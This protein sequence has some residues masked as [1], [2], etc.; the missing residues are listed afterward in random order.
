MWKNGRKIFSLH[1]LFAAFSSAKESW[2]QKQW[3]LSLMM[4]GNK[5][6]LFAVWSSPE[7]ETKKNTL[8]S[9]TDRHWWQKVSPGESD[10]MDGST[11]SNLLLLVHFFT[12][13]E[14][15]C[16]ADKIWVMYK[17]YEIL[18]KIYHLQDHTVWENLQKYGG[19]LKSASVAS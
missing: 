15:H 18:L 7:R 4:L 17:L 14:C 10:I 19:F 8:L 16:I 6:L 13:G 11:V 1:L 9:F 12:V 3:K 2:S 5:V